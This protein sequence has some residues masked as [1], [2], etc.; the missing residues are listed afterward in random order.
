MSL[1]VQN[2]QLWVTELPLFL[3]TTDTESPTL[4]IEWQSQYQSYIQ[5]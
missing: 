3:Q 5:Y 2:E 4:K 1:Y